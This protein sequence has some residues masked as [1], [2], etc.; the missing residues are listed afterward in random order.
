MTVA[1]ALDLGALR[2]AQ[3]EIERTRLA[4]VPPVP[5]SPSP[6]P[7]HLLRVVEG[8]AQELRARAFRPM[9]R[10]TSFEHAVQATNAGWKAFCELWPAAIAALA[11]WISEDPSRL[12]SFLPRSLGTDPWT[13]RLARRRLGGPSCSNWASAQDARVAV[14]KTLVRSPR[15]SPPPL[16]ETTLRDLAVL[17][18]QADFSIMF[19]LS[20]IAERTAPTLAMGVAEWLSADAHRNARAAYSMIAAPLYRDEDAASPAG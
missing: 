6:L 7:S 3:T 11:P 15:G 14:A 5:E 9:M 4:F 18:A 1:A 2:S 10:A 19:G 20:V 13:S 8:I 16:D 12:L 17:V